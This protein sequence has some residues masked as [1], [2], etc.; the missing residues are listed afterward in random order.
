[1]GRE[2]GRPTQ[3][4]SPRVASVVASLS[5]R[6]GSIGDNGLGGWYS[7]RIS[8][9]CRPFFLRGGRALSSRRLASW[10]PSFVDKAAL[11]MATKNMSLEFKRSGVW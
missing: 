2:L 8:K 11:N 6:V 10:S 7:Y 4:V 9:V 5:A 3:Q 1:M